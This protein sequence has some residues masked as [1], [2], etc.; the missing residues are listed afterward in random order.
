VA[1]TDEYWRGL[2]LRKDVCGCGG[3]VLLSLS[4]G[5]LGA[6]L[7]LLLLEVD[8]KLFVGFVVGEVFAVECH[9]FRKMWLIGALMSSKPSAIFDSREAPLIEVFSRFQA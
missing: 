4:S 2:N 6:V 8:F 1:F 9:I 3:S 5:R 7:G